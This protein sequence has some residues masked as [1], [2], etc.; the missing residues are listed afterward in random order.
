[1]ADNKVVQRTVHF[2]NHHYLADTTG[3]GWWRHMFQINTMYCVQDQIGMQNTYSRLIDVAP[4]FYR[5]MN[6]V[7]IQRWTTPDLYKLVKD[8]F[9]PVFKQT[10]TKLIYEIDDLT[11]ANYIPLY[12]SGREAFVSVETQEAIKGM[13]QLSD[14]VVVTTQ[15]LKEM[16]AKSYDLPM[17]KIKCIPNLL[18]HWWIGDRY[19]PERKVQQFNRYRSRPR[20]GVI[21]SLSHYNMR[22]AVDGDGKP[23]Q[24][25]LDVIL[26]LI[27]STTQD[28]QWV[29]LGG[30]VSPKIAD[31][32]S[33]GK[34]QSI[35]TCPFLEYPSYIH[36]LQL[37]AVV[38]PL[39]DNEFNH[40]KSFIKYEECSALGIPLYASKMLPYVE[41][42][43]EDQLFS[44]S[45]ELK[46][47]LMKLKFGSA[48]AYGKR[49]AAQMNWLNSPTNS[50]DVV[51]NNWWL[52]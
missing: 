44:D 41:V 49:I 48:G 4:N 40:C 3:T 11:D 47:Q 1:M 51:L 46:S 36:N 12:N 17:E 27:R 13:L 39:Q 30:N 22:N 16:M 25:D 29:I 42:M 10:G 43:P 34:V 15:K 23:V 21:S 33:S 18:P 2:R 45:N 14:Y 32:V 28:F 35:S 19:D 26:D 50:G 20:I 38:A 8:F 24:D 5:G 37:Q 7:W 6:S 9:V 52:E 31:L